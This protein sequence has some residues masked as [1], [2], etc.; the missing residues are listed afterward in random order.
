MKRLAQLASVVA[1]S[2]FAAPAQAQLATFDD[3]AQC[4]QSQ[5]DNAVFAVPGGYSGF[6]WSNFFVGHGA[7]TAA[8][9]SGPG[10]AS[11]TVTNPCMALNG[12]GQPAEITAAN[13]F[14]FNGG[15]F[16]AAFQDGLFL[17]VVGYSGATQLFSTSL[18][19]NTSG[20]QLMDVTWEGVDRIRFESGSGSPGSQFVF[21]NFRFNNTPDPAIPSVPEPGT[22]ILLATG[23]CAGLAV[24]KRRRPLAPSSRTTA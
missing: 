22:L 3:L 6:N 21:D 10:Y 15:F 12:F 18:T 13:P 20:P 1:F 4:Q 16:T 8:R 19:L 2:A 7:T 14:I 17:S 11:G 24:R 9:V 23:L 5:T